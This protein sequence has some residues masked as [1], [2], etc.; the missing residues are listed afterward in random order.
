MD[1]RIP[2]PGFQ[3]LFSLNL[4][5]GFHSFAGFLIPKPRIRDSTERSF[6]RIPLHVAYVKPHPPPKRKTKVRLHVG[7]PTWGGKYLK[8][9]AHDS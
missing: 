3:S 1:F 7:Y 6:S 9:I 8:F 2:G 4:D 5:S